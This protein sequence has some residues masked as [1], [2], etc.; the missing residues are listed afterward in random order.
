[1]KCVALALAV[2]LVTQASGQSVSADSNPKVRAITSFVRLNPATYEKQVSDA[3]ARRG[4]E[5]EG[6]V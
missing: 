2:L 3:L 5:G 1:M 6:R 4:A